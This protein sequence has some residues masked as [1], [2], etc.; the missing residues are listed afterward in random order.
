MASPE[1]GVEGGQPERQTDDAGIQITLTNGRRMMIP[2]AALFPFHVAA[3]IA[4]PVGVKV[5][6]AG[7][8]A[9]VRCG[10][11]S[12]V[13]KVRGLRRDPHGGAL[14]C[15]RGRKGD[16]IQ[17]LCRRGSWRRRAD[18]VSYNK[19]NITVTYASHSCRSRRFS[20]N[21]S[22][23]LSISGTNSCR[24]RRFSALRLLPRPPGPFPPRMRR[25]S[26]R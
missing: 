26:I 4:F 20:G 15:F 12:L 23:G 16:L 24:N 18:M 11:N 7:G 1:A 10:R 5:W 9:D 13:L 21:F 19:F 14:F 17:V 8:I 3:M 2:A 22:A 6:I 25:S